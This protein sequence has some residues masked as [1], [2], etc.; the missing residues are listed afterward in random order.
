MTPPCPAANDHFQLTFEDHAD[1]LCVR[2][3]GEFDIATVCPVDFELDRRVD[4]LTRHVVFDLRDVTFL[5]LA[6]LRVLIRTNARAR[7]EPYDVQVI[8]PTGPARRLF[9]L[10]HSDGVLTLVPA[11]AA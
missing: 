3:A 9:P 7:S 8:A 11:V 6:G 5:D 1:T 4:A 10:T 2:V